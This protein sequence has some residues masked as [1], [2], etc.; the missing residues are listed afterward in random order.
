MQV[1]RK[2]KNKQVFKKTFSWIFLATGLVVF[3]VAPNLALA[4][5]VDTGL[6][7][8]TALGLGTTDI[9]ETI[10]RIVQVAL[11]FLGTLAVLIVLYAGFL[12]MTS[13]GDESR[14]QQAKDYLRNG[15]IGLV[16][17]LTSFGIVTFILQS[18]IGGLQAPT[19]APPGGVITPTDICRNCSAIGGGLIEAV[20]PAPGATEIPRNTNIIVTFKEEVDPNSIITG[21]GTVNTDAVKIYVFGE[22][23]STAIANVQVATIDNLTFVFN[24]VENLGNNLEAVWYSVDLMGGNNG[25]QLLDGTNGWPNGVGF[26]W[27]FQVSN[28]LDLHPPEL[29]TQFPQPDNLADQYGTVLAQ[30]A[31]GAIIVTDIPQVDSNPTAEF[32]SFTPTQPDIIGTYNGLNDESLVTA[33]FGNP[34][35]GQVTITWQD[36]PVNNGVL[37][38][39]AGDGSVVLPL[40]GGLSLQ[41]PLGGFND[42]DLFTLSATAEKFA[43]A[44]TI[45]NITFR[46][47]P[48]V[49]QGNQ[50]QIFPTDTTISVAN[51]IATAISGT[52]FNPDVLATPSGSQINLTAAVVGSSGNN[53]NLGASG[54]GRWV[55]LVPMSGGQDDTSAVLTTNHVP[56]QPKNAIVQ[57]R[58]DEALDPTVVEGLV[59]NGFDNLQV[60]YNNGGTWTTAEGQFIT[61]NQ[62]RTVEFI[63]ANACEDGS[64]NPISNS[65]GDPIF[66]LPT[67]AGQGATQYRVTT[68]AAT[69]NRC[70][71]SIDCTDSPYT[72]CTGTPPNAV[73]Q[74]GDGNNHP[75]ASF[76]AD[77][78]IDA[79]NNS[80]DGD[81]DQLAEQVFP[82]TNI[83]DYYNLNPTSPAP[84]PDP[85]PPHD[86]DSVVWSF[87]IRD[88]IDLTP[89][90]LTSLG[91]GPGIQ[92]LDVALNAVPAGDFDKLMRESTIK[93][94]SGYRDGYC[95]CVS[96]ADCLGNQICSPLGLC[97]DPNNAND[98]CAQDNEC[99]ASSDGCHNRRYISLQSQST[100]G[101]GYWLKS[102]AS[103]VTPPLDGYPDITSFLID[104]SIFEAS[105]SYGVEVGSGLQDIYQNCFL[106]STGPDSSGGTCS[107]APYCCN[108]QPLDE[109]GWQAS[110]CANT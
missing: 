62:Y 56:D 68:R 108:G 29:V 5:Q 65:C 18:V 98:Y 53:I 8:A 42:A 73:C 4:L 70:N 91:S 7:Y 48:T 97:V 30:A 57:L 35:S 27:N 21:T 43:D 102:Q 67:V 10:L 37:N 82:A 86:G 92:Q 64:G 47:V 93:P 100:G 15:L 88:E 75:L 36:N 25:V 40:G 34:A 3:F 80:L 77:G 69:L 50:I 85:A 19:G 52:T 20:Y 12:W 55:T 17:I 61:S 104:H 109:A 23:P 72:F 105:T 59:A 90:I 87:W 31:Q 6:N 81:R 95:G 107:G 28:F 110:V 32:I 94:G 101:L 99:S 103:D 49:P 41:R 106:P 46:F 1:Q 60:Q 24:P 74:D 96:D 84:Q 16:I 78:V 63:P 26:G 71:T 9:R 14:I 38:Y 83:D 44:L 2:Q 79:A 11:G 33:D 45:S 22:D 54:V 76:P 58:F 89:P 51:R 39:I 66:C 13:G